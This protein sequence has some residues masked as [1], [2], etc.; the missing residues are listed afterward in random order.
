MYLLDVQ[1]SAFIGK[2]AE[3]TRKS[4]FNFDDL[5]KYFSRFNNTKV[6]TIRVFPGD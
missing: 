2:K 1:I 5:I 6:R 3:R 4:N